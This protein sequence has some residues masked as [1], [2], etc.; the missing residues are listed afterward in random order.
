M[1]SKRELSAEEIIRT[2]EQVRTLTSIVNS[3][4]FPTEYFAERMMFEH[5]T[6]QQSTMRLFIAIIREWS[7]QEYYDLRN[8]ATIKLSKKIINA[9]DDTDYL[10]FV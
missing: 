4:T 3:F 6:L 5:R 2:E 8:E 9:L 10:P 1:R 7:Q